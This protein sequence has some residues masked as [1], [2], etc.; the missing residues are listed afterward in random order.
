MWQKPPKPT[1]H[2]VFKIPETSEPAGLQATSWLMAPDCEGQSSPQVLQQST[3]EKH[4][5][6]RAVLFIE[7][8]YLIQPILPI[9]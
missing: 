5:H 1:H 7:F 9:F 6:S 8:L 3:D 4:L 2:K